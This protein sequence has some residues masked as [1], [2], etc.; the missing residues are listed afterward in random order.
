MAYGVL[1]DIATPAERGAYIGAVFI[2]YLSIPK[3]L[4]LLTWEI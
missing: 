2:G 3:L 1:S 4:P